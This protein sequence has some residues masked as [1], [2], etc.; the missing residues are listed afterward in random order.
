MSA[1]RVRSVV[2]KALGLSGTTYDYAR[3]GRMVRCLHRC[4][5]TADNQRIRPNRMES[6][7]SPLKEGGL[8]LG[9]EVERADGLCNERRS[10]MAKPIEPTPVLKGK[11]AKRLLKNI[12]RPVSDPKKATFLASCDATYQALAR[13]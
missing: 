9:C 2:G 6:R 12:T 4:P 10:D 3:Q 11:D 13:K 7:Y 8:P 1:N 5:A